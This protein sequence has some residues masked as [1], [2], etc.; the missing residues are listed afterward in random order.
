VACPEKILIVDDDP[1][2]V[3]SFKDLMGS[4]CGEDSVV[5]AR[6]G[7]EALEMLRSGLRP[8]R[9]ITDLRMPRMSGEEFIDALRSSGF[10]DIPVITMTGAISGSPATLGVAVHLKKPFTNMRLESAL[11]AT[12]GPECRPWRRS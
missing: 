8:C 6:D 7:L 2:L 9:I 3:L 11:I 12:A 10:G 4:I 1:G 5:T